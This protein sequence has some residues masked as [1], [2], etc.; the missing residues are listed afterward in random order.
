MAVTSTAQREKVSNLVKQGLMATF[1]I[2][3]PKLATLL[4]AAIKQLA[5]SHGVKEL[6]SHSHWRKIFN[7]ETGT[8]DIDYWIELEKVV[9]HIIEEQKNKSTVSREKLTSLH[10]KINSQIHSSK[11]KIRFGYFPNQ[12][13]ILPFFFRH[14]YN[15][16]LEVQF[17]KFDNWNDGLKAFKENKIDV[18]LR[19]FATTV[20]FNSKM[21]N[22]H[23]LFFYPLFSFNGYFIFA[24]QS[25][26]KEVAAKYRATIKK[27]P[28]WTDEAKRELFE[29]KSNKIILEKG[30][31]FEWALLN[32]CKGFGCDINKVK[33]NIVHWNTN[34]GDTE[35][36]KDKYT[37][38]CTNPL[39]SSSLLKDKQIVSIGHGD[40]L[41][42]HHNFNGIL[43]T[44]D[45]LNRNEDAVAQL[46]ATWFNDIVQLKR[47]LKKA[48]NKANDIDELLLPSLAD[49]LNKEI[50]STI[51]D[52]DLLRLF[53]GHNT[54]YETPKSAFDKFYKEILKD[55]CP[56][57]QN[58]REIALTQLGKDS[59][60]GDEVLNKMNLI[61]NYMNNL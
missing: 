15:R 35:F 58:Y 32:F 18:A 34:D 49:F 27:F 7:Y 28:Q 44:I 54:F 30:T 57:F 41:G 56:M 22:K 33:Q 5:P 12:D 29:S 36:M 21:G 6:K 53:D 20:A 59:D 60:E 3:N 55:D 45:F 19:D 1:G 50:P 13:T 48:N 2:K 51:K 61:K 17:I 52:T 14:S 8:D 43:C 24:K 40:S 16:N 31:D 23:P 42:E 11:T 26:F 4:N 37:I 46:I 25:K 39:N 47:D 9:N 10:N 38:H